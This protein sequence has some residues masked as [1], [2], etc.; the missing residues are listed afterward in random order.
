MGH[1][2]G[3]AKSWLRLS[4]YHSILWKERVTQSCP[5]LCNP[6]DCSLPGSSVHRILQAR[7]MEWVAIPFSRG[8][9]WLRGWTQVSRVDRQ[10]LYHLSYQPKTRML[11]EVGF[12]KRELHE[13]VIFFL[14]I[15]FFSPQACLSHI[16]GFLR[17][18]LWCCRACGPSRSLSSSGVWMRERAAR[19]PLASRLP[20]GPAS[21]V[22]SHS[23][24]PCVTGIQ[25]VQVSHTW[26]ASLVEVGVEFENAYSIQMPLLL[27]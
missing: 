12:I 8:S 27:L 17:R 6:M 22:F 19:R 23:Q 20:P 16:F 2:A 21:L 25:R 9:S 11:S 26:E 3:V 18:S 13:S 10:I 5:T 1:S 24:W 15:R 4:T 7:I 14:H